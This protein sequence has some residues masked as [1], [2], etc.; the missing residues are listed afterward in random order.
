M[1]QAIVNQGP[2]LVLF[3]AHDTNI[4]SFSSALQ[5]MTV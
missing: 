1:K 5:L 4:M 2:K 3:S